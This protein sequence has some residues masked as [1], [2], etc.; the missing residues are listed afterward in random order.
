VLPW[1]IEAAA[2]EPDVTCPNVRGGP[3]LGATI[4]VWRGEPEKAAQLVAADE[5]ASERNTLADRGVTARYA[6][7]IGRTDV[8]AAIVD[9]MGHTPDRERYPEGFEEFFETLR[10]LGRDDDVRNFLAPARALAPAEVLLG[11]IADRAEGELALEAGSYEEARA[12]LEP[13]VTTF[14][15]LSVPFEAAQTRELLARASKPAEA[16]QLLEAAL[17]TYRR[18]RATP[19]AARVEGAL[20][21]LPDN[22]SLAGG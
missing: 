3:S 6:A 20:A 5:R 2:A 19:S 12:L 18:L 8:A 15:R 9:R 16:R 14:D 7:L 11:P 21:R 10:I 4:L 1:H 22:V 17:E 13:A